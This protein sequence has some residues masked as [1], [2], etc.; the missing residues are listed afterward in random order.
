VTLN[1]VIEVGSILSV[2]VLA[3]VTAGSFLLLA[4]VDAATGSSAERMQLNV[5]EWS[6][7]GRNRWEQLTVISLLLLGIGFRAYALGAQSLWFDEAIT[8]NAAVATLETGRPTFPSGYTYWRAFTHTMFVTASMFVF[9]VSEWAARV[10]SVLFGGGSILLTYWLGRDVGGRTVG[11]LAAGLITFATWEIAWSRQARMY[12]LFQLLYL[13]AI[14]LLLRIDAEGF[15]DRRRLAALIVVIGLAAAT[16]PIGY[17]LLPVAISFLSITA[18]ADGTVDRRTGAVIGG[19]AIVVTGLLELVGPGLTGALETIT[20]TDVN[21]WDAYI[22]WGIRELHGFVYLA[23][24]G[25]SITAYVGNYRAGLLCAIAVLP[26]ALILSFSTQLFATRYLYFI[27]PFIFVW[28][29]VTVLFVS[30]K[31]TATTEITTR[32]PL[33]STVASTVLGITIVCL[34]L[35]GGGFTLTPQAEYQLGVNAPQPAFNSAYE[36]VT[37][38]RGDDAVVIAG[39]TAP[40]VYYAG[41]V[42]YWLAHDL[43]GTGGSY[44]VAGGERYSGAEPIRSATELETVVAEHEQVWVVLDRTAYRRQPAATQQV[45]SA[46]FVVVHEASQIAVYRSQRTG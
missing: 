26:P 34:L 8:T 22:S 32:S 46:E 45:L 28:A 42:E 20:T 43:T 15:D 39:W 24:A 31:L 10:P 36:H 12:Q 27:L 23:I 44:T 33:T 5:S 6:W 37:A 38:N 40:G 18:V 17:I 19:T 25:T 11:L 7:F 4:G 21:Y 14:V 35:L 1:V 13:L 30:R 3:G 9:G 2:G 41:G 16:H 29:A